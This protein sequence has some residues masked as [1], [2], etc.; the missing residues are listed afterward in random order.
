MHIFW[1]QKPEKKSA[2]GRTT[3][4]DTIRMDITEIG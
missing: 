2:L 3:W 1:L 4:E